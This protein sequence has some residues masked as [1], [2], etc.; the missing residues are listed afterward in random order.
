MN[1]N[2]GIKPQIEKAVL[3][4]GISNKDELEGRKPKTIVV[5]WI[6]EEQLNACLKLEDL[7]KRLEIEKYSPELLDEA[8]QIIKSTDIFFNIHS[9]DLPKKVLSRMLEEYNGGNSKILESMDGE[10]LSS[11][12]KFQAITDLK[13]RDDE[14]TLKILS[15]FLINGLNQIENT[16]DPKLAIEILETKNSL[17]HGDNEKRWKFIS[18][19]LN[20]IYMRNNGISPSTAIQ[21]LDVITNNISG[22]NK[23]FADYDSL[24]HFIARSL[25][26][27][28]TMEAR[29]TIDIVINLIHKSSSFEN[30]TVIVAMMNIL[31]RDATYAVSQ[32]M[33][34]LKIKEDVSQYP[35]FATS[36][37][38]R[39]LA[40]PN[41]LVTKLLYRLEFGNVNIS[42]EGV[43]YL[44]KRYD[45]VQMNNPDYFVRRLTANGEVGVFNEKRILVKYFN[46]G[47][48]SAEEEIMKPEV[49]DFVYETLF[50]SNA[51]ESPEEKAK[52]ENYL[53]EFKQNYFGFYNDDFFKTTGVAFNNLN[54]REQGW[55]LLFHR[56]AEVEDKESLDKFV[57][58]YG[59]PGLKSFLS[60]EFGK[61]VGGKIIDIG[62]K[63]KYKEAQLIFAKIA[64]IVDAVESDIAQLFEG[65]EVAFN[66]DEV[67]LQ[68]L[69]KAHQ[70]IID[71]SGELEK[72][73]GVEV[74]G[75]LKELQRQ[76]T[77][78]KI[79]A[80]ALLVMKK[81]GVRVV[82]EMIKD[83][84]LQI[85]DYGEE[86][87]QRDRD[88]MYQ[89]ADVNWDQNR[90]L[91]PLVLEGLRQGLEDSKSQKFYI[92]RYKGN[93]ISFARFLPSGAGI[94]YFGSV[95]LEPE[96]HGVGMGN[97]LIEVAIEEEGRDTILEAVTAPQLK[98]GTDYV[99]KTGFVIDGL[100]AD[101]HHTGELIFAIRR[102]PGKNQDYRFRNEYKPEDRQATW[103]DIKWMYQEYED[104]N[105]LVGSNPIILRYDISADM[106]KMKQELS[107]LLP[108]KDDDLKDIEERGNQPKYIA[109]R[110]VRDRDEKERDVRYLVLEKVS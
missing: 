1:E 49:L 56:Q 12:E 110:Y 38:T 55:F 86:L 60:L 105:E 88:E 87:G 2:L 36:G 54:F 97:A 79:L 5:P 37:R 89:M 28:N 68:L 52:R 67:R 50:L 61:D 4:K 18:E 108:V 91:K 94:K 76:K 16:Q 35:K 82:P 33:S 26:A 39:T 14:Q 98:V 7:E 32:L 104:I 74:D 72:G 103:K 20:N 64:E 81:N 80:A 59:E 90:T 23:K 95:N 9:F 51:N 57:R 17:K 71:F 24:P 93:V 99:E 65:N 92:H 15:N 70:I 75:L 69:R 11:L 66:V 73:E 106:D 10:F 101:Y 96:L 77:E 21:T 44:N 31:N 13:H 47:D 46:L 25:Y 107:Q 62:K 102:D 27:L 78:N 48:L 84:E 100:I 58:L 3:E 42:K 109:T 29:D 41:Q 30:S 43:D 53:E 19:F 45:L 40:K 8:L 63:F 83:F 22:D 85:K 6:N 34:L